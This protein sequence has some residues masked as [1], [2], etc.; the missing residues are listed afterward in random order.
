MKK[1][2]VSAP[3]T[4]ANIGCGFDTLGVALEL[5]NY[6]S[7]EESE[8]FEVLEKG[9]KINGEDLVVKI[10]TNYLQE[11]GYDGNVKIVKESNIPPRK[12][13]GSSSAAIVSALGAVMCFL[14]KL[15]YETLFKKS[16]KIEGHP[17]NVAPAVFGGMRLSAKI[18]EKYFS[19]GIPSPFKKLV[20]FIPP[21][22]ISTELARRALAKNVSLESAVFNLQR[23]AMLVAAAFRGKTSAWHFDDAIHQEKRLSLC[24]EARDFFTTLK[25]TEVPVF[26]C[27]SGPSIAVVNDANSV[28]TPFKWRKLEL[29]VSMEGLKI[30]NMEGLNCW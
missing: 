13:L 28:I 5:R 23:V 16:V 10:V 3:A 4:V 1:V 14:G 26:L 19:E 30:E 24:K 15:N 12:G 7:I 29:P 9:E 8:Y 25:K 2:S 20:V 27:G 22:E 21:C 11:N 6:V 18:G 17:D